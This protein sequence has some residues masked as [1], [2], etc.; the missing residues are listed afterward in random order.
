MSRLAIDKLNPNS[1]EVWMTQVQGY[2]YY[3][4]LIFSVLLL[5][6]KGMYYSYCFS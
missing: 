2:F 5:L 6:F 4:Y 1:D 3:M